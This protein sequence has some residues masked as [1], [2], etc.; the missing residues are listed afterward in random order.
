LAVWL[1]FSSQLAA[2]AGNNTYIP[3]IA[4]LQTEFQPKKSLQKPERGDSLNCLRYFEQTIRSLREDG[5]LAASVDEMKVQG[6]SLIAFIHVG[7]RIDKTMIDMSRIPQEFAG[8]KSRPFYQDN[9]PIS[10][11]KLN[12]LFEDL[13]HAYEENGYPFAAVRLD[14]VS[15][16]EEVFRGIVK[17]EPGRLVTID[18]IVMNGVEPVAPVFIHNYLGILPGSVYKESD[19]AAIPVR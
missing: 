16:R 2:G 7:Q 8:T 3:T 14:S 19:L 18:S 1:V 9:R 12:R 4:F 11:K 10:A 13:L 17:V 6:D 5:F 15:I